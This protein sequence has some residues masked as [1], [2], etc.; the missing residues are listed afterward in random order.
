MYLFIIIQSGR[1][2]SEVPIQQLTAV[3]NV[4]QYLALERW[5][6]FKNWTDISLKIFI[7]IIT[8][9]NV[10]LVSIGDWLYCNLHDKLG[11]GSFPLTF[12][13][14]EKVWYF[15]LE[16]YLPRATS[17]LGLLQSQW[18]LVIERFPIGCYSLQ[19]RAAV[20][21]ACRQGVPLDCYRRRYRDRL[22][23]SC[24]ER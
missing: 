12:W 22:V 17:S 10:W 8:E 19:T 4:I 20:P 18:C 16:F 14:K 24:G 23:F 3:S 15:V 1:C 2:L 21:G 7:E 9:P 11:F 13:I 5:M 6:F